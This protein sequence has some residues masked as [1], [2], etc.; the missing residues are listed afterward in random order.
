MYSTSSIKELNAKTILSLITDY[1]IFSYYIKNKLE[2]GKTINSPLRKDNNPSFQIYSCSY[3]FHRLMFMDFATRESGSCFAL[4][5]R[6][7]NCNFH[8]ALLIVDRDFNLGISSYGTKPIIGRI[9]STIKSLTTIVQDK[10]KIEVCIRDW[11]S[12][13]DKDYWTQYSVSCATL[14]K[15]NVYPLAYYR[16]NDGLSKC[17]SITYGYYFGNGLWKIYSPLSDKRYKWLSNTNAETLQGWSQL[18]LIGTTLVITK[19]LKDVMLLHELGI[20]SIAPQSESIVIS[21]DRITELKN[22]FSRIYLLFD[23]DYAGITTS[24]KYKKRYKLKTL[25]LTNGRFST[26]DYGAKDITDY[27]KLYGK[28][29]L[30]ELINKVKN[31]E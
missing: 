22:R 24:N 2:I 15:F 12:T 9:G 26:I 14:I 7:F 18:P 10:T 13:T 19:S 28:D 6:L 16:I 30:Q 21:E 3:G 5:M 4:V 11:N 31:E 25:Y 17:T 20:S 27:V 1:D 29:K 8:N 23:Y